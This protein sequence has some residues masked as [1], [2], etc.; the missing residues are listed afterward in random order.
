MAT[1]RNSTIDLAKFIAAFLV[2]AIHTQ[3]LEDLNSNAY[4]VFNQLIC[5]LAVPFFAACTGYFLCVGGGNK[6]SSC[7][8]QEKKL[9]TLYFLWTLLYF[10]YL[11]P[12]WMQTHY[13]SLT[14][15][16]GFLK[17]AVLCGS[18]FHLWY[19]LDIIYS[20]P[21][22]YLIMRYVHQRWWEPLAIVLWVICALDYGYSWLLPPTVST[23]LAYTGKGYEMLHS[24]FVLLPMMLVG[25]AIAKRRNPLSIKHSIILLLITFTLLVLEG[26][27][28]QDHG[29]RE[30]TRIL[31][32]LPVTYSL[33]S[34]L[35]VIP[36]QS[37]VA[38]RLA[39]L[40]LIIY[41]VHPM[42]CQYTNV[43]FSTVPSFIIASS[44]STMV[45]VIWVY[46]EEKV[47]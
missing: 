10:L 45:A 42:F 40:S 29:H 1:N 24:Q 30:V 19:V 32:I 31:M 35:L 12:T 25:A 22:Y 26:C 3:F 20:L 44:L 2:V 8:R 38:P 16:L 6:W 33:L 39:R 15:C 21:V 43:A 18:Y 14:A 47:K 36:L 5:R 41:C 17:S 28:L 37:S 11:L 46:V 27:L 9:V 23:V 34:L 7:V 4:F 13:L